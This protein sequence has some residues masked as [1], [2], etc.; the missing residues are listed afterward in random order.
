MPLPARPA[1][2]SESIKASI[3]HKAVGAFSIESDAADP[4]FLLLV[5][6]G[7]GSGGTWTPWKRHFGDLA[8]RDA[9]LERFQ[10]GAL[11]LTFLARLTMI[12]GPATITKAVDR[13]VESGRKIRRAQ[14]E[15][16]DKRQ[17]DREIINLYA[18]DTKRCFKLALQRKSDDDAEWSVR[19]D[20]AIE[21]DRLC[22]FVRWQ[23]ARFGTFLDY[24]AKNGGEAL[25]RMLTDEMFET[26][27]RIKQQ[28]RGAGGMRPLRMWRGD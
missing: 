6:N 23:K 7:V 15:S 24:A 4:H 5:I 3:V 26:E 1:A 22:D 10:S 12:F 11:D 28:G 18:P 20:R 25:T 16:E 19:Y 17:R 9:V 13:V 8:D 2:T 14:A 27:A 21:R